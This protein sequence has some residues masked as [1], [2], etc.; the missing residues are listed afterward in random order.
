MKILSITAQKPHSTGSGTYLTELV[1]SYHRAGHTQAVVC[2]VFREDDVHFPEEVKCYPVFYS[3][4]KNPDLNAD[5][6][7]PVI[8]MS[9]VM[10]YESTRYCD[11]TPSDID[12][13]EAS[14]MKTVSQAVED[15][16]PDVILCHHLFLLT[17]FVRK[18][19][20]DRKIFGMCHGSDL[21]QVINCTHMRD[22]VCPQ[23]AKLDH[24]FALH[25]RQRHKIS[26]LFNIEASRI[27][28][29]GSGYNSDLFNSEGRVLHNPDGPVR[30][31][32]AGK[33]SDAKGV[34]ELL[35]ALSD[36]AKDPSIPEFTVQLAG[37]CTSDDIRYDIENAESCIV[38]LGQIPQTQLADTFRNSD[39]FILPSFYEGLGLVLIEAMACG[40]RCISTDLPGIQDWINTNVKN[41]AVKYIPMPEMATV[42]EPTEKGRYKFISDL[43]ALLSEAI[44]ECHSNGELSIH[45]D[46]SLISWDHVAETILSF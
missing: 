46:L 20:P 17:S 45:P 4:R 1:N 42:D 5:L 26:E 44:R 6:P 8:G 39:I 35:V 22:I 28:A 10:P 3:H 23:I 14:F 29:V 21:R 43:K 18:N 33:M 34:P 11:L 9:D 25:D 13:F 31:C 24:I 27:T 41:P 2:G 32:Y 15:I 40:L 19:F 38:W 12:K 7:F 37:G 16:D 30:I 36:L